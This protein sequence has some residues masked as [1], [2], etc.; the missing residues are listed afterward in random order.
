[1]SFEVREPRGVERRTEVQ[2]LCE[3][4]DSN[5]DMEAHLRGLRVPPSASAWGSVILLVY[6]LPNPLPNFRWIF[7]MRVLRARGKILVVAA[8][9]KG[10]VRRRRHDDLPIFE[11]PVWER[12]RAD[13]RIVSDMIAKT[14]HMRLVR[15]HP[16]WFGR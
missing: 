4:G 6:L 12:S 5:L 13:R 3:T 8:A 9:C 16:D 11:I 15:N 1:M 2:C 14:A 10:A 7:K